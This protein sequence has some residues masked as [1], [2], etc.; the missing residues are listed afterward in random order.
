MHAAAAIHGDVDVLLTRNL[1]HLRTKPVLDAG[2]KVSTSDDFLCE[3]LT[4]HRSQGVYGIVHPR[5]GQQEEPPNDS[6]GNW[7]TKISTAGA[8]RFA[9][10]LRPNLAR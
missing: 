2:V 3:L 9:E 4:P 10:R 1:K 6:P 8:P 7:P 5:G